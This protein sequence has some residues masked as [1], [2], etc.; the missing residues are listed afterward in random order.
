MRVLEAMSRRLHAVKFRISELIKSSRFRISSNRSEQAMNASKSAERPGDSTW[1]FLC[2]ICGTHNE[3]PRELVVREGGNCRK[4]RATSRFRSIAYALSSHLF[5]EH[6]ILAEAQPDKSIRGIGC[7]DALCYASEFKRLFDYTNTFFHCTPFLDLCNVNWEEFKPGSY[8]FLICSDVLEHIV[9][10]VERAFE[11]I[12]K[13]LKPTGI[14]VLTVP[15]TL[16]P[17]TIEHFP[18]LEK[19]RIVEEDGRK[20]LINERSNG[21]IERFENL[22]FHGGLGATL[23]IRLFSREGLLETNARAGLRSARIL[24]EPVV[25]YGITLRA[26]DLVLIS[27]VAGSQ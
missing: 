27:E 1:P 22:C 16:E 5:S 2:N 20:V 15:A 13:L 19:W 3:L 7:S 4:C 25:E 24:D 26:H 18:N 9:P 14:A 12:R 11:G 6:T 23:E 21:E 8:D 10:P 17:E